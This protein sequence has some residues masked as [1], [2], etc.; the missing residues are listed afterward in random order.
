M[1]WKAR[2]RAAFASRT[3]PD[4]DIVEELAQHAASAFEAACWASSSTMSSSGMVRDANAART[5]AFQSILSSPRPAS[6]RHPA[7]GVRACC[8]GAVQPGKAAGR[9]PPAAGPVSGLPELHHAIEGE[10]EAFPDTALAGEH[11]PA[12]G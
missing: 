12:L 8:P 9:K 3:I 1:D 2:V 4:D 11:L 5:L 7:C 10:E 6:A